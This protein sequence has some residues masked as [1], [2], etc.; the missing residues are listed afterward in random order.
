MYLQNYSCISYT[1]RHEIHI[2]ASWVSIDDSLILTATK[3]HPQIQT[4]IC[5]IVSAIF[6]RN[7][8][9]QSGSPHSSCSSPGQRMSLTKGWT[10]HH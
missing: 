2:I 7:Y 6:V 4:Q 3:K 9:I 8:C 1:S 10:F 5:F